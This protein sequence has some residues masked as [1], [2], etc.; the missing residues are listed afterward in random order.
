MHDNRE[1]KLA[2]QNRDDNNNQARSCKMTEQTLAAL[3]RL[4]VD[5]GHNGGVSVRGW[6]QNQTLVRARVEAWAPT[7]SEASLIAG[8][9]HV[10]T[11]SGLLRA[12]GPEGLKDKGWAVSWEVFTPHATDL[13]ATAHNGGV[14][15]SDIRGRLEL[16]AHNGGVHL[17]R[18]AGDI[19]GTTHNGGIHVE[20]NSAENGQ[21]NF[22]THNG[23]VHL[24]LPGNYSARVHAE[25][26]NGGIHSDFP[27]PEPPRGERRVRNVDFNIGSGGP[28]INLKTHNGGVHISRL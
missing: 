26:N 2:C 6:S 22:S 11:S 1:K 7:E 23:G 10:E 17:A 12:T 25:T 15:I 28:S 20:V 5:A 18:V 3:G 4:S 16:K 21:L 27:L 14:H 19:S 13:K 9:I 24:S 8:Q